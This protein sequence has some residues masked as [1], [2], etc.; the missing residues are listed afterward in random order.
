VTK[1]RQAHVRMRIV[2]WKVQHFPRAY[3][4][5]SATILLREINEVIDEYGCDMTVAEILGVLDLAKDD[6]L[7]RTREYVGDDYFPDCS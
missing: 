1:L 7:E 6:T 4:T 2:R 5:K 3:F